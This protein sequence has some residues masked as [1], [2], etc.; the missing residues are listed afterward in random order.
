MLIVMAGIP[1]SRLLP[2]AD[3]LMYEVKANGRNRILQKELG[4]EPN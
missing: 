1:G 2:E 4:K 3:K